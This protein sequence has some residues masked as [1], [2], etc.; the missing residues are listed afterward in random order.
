[1]DAELQSRLD[2]IER[3]TLLAAKDV[4]SVDDLALYMGRSRKTIYNIV[5]EI[6]HYSNGRGIWFKREEVNAYLCRV[7]HTP[8]Y[9]ILN[10]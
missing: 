7:K 4:F 1:M 5:D 9:S 2:R 6:P 10:Q 8:I 3:L